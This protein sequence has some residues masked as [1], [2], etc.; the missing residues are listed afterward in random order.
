MSRWSLDLPTEVCLWWEEFAAVVRHGHTCGR[1][2]AEHTL[3]LKKYQQKGWQYS[4][5]SDTTFSLILKIGALNYYGQLVQTK[6]IFLTFTDHVE[7]RVGNPFVL[8]QQSS[9][10]L[11]SHLL[12]ERQVPPD[13]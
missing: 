6:V 2:H 1:G 12:L 13:R 11:V 5:R 8:L 10:Q 3:Y 4:P 7:V 9:S